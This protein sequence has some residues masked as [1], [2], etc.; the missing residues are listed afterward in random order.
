[1][2]L[3]CLE[4]ILVTVTLTEYCDIDSVYIFSCALALDVPRTMSFDVASMVANSFLIL[5][6]TTP[7]SLR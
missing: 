5:I 3:V 6:L 2:E 7:V 1:M 4:I